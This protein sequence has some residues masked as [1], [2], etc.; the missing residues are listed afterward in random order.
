MSD[1][2]WSPP[3]EFAQATN[4]ARFMEK[5]GIEDVRSLL[6]RSV[7][8]HE[9][10]WDAIVEDL[11]IEFAEPYHTVVDA[12]RGN[13]WA[14]W[15]IGG[16][17]N[18]TAN[19]L[20]RHAWSDHADRVCL[21]SEREDGAV[22]ELTFSELFKL[23]ERCAAALVSLGVGKGDRVAAFMPMTHDVVVQMLAT[24]K[25]GAVFIPIFKGFQPEA[26]VTRLRDA[27]PKV[28]FAAD[29]SYWRGETVPIKGN[30]DAALSEVPGIRH[31]IVARYTDDDIVWNLDR[32]IAWPD[33]LNR[34]EPIP[35]S[36]M[37]AMD[38]AL[39]LYTS[40]T[41]GSAKGTVH[42]HA[43]ALVQIAK[44][45]GY[46][47]DVK[48]DDR[49]FWLTDIGWMMGPWSIIGGL[50]HGATVVLYDGLFD[51]PS[52]DRLWEMLARHRVTV[53]GVSPTV[54]RIFM[55]RDPEEVTRHDLSSLRILGS[56]GEPCDERT[57]HWYFETVGGSRCPV[58][59]V[60]GG[61]DILGS[62]LSPL[63]IVPLK[64]CSLAAPGLGMAVDVWSED[65][66][67]VRD[68]V[69]YL[70]ATKPAPSMTRGLWND[71][72]RYMETYWSTWPE[73]WNHG[74]WAHID[75]DGCWFVHGRADDTIKV[76]GR[77][78]GPAEI[79][80]ALMASGKVAEA[81]AVGVPHDVKGEGI[82]CFVV[83]NPGQ[84]PSEELRHELL[85]SVVGRLGKVCKPDAILF[86]SDL[87]KTSNAMILRR[88]VRDTYLGRSI[89]D[90]TS[91][92]NPEALRAITDA[93]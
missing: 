72:D 56:T 40:G 20:E 11:G 25:I 61:T 28:L 66:K 3:P 77:R 43:G 49:L 47:F 26:M 54:M 84:D 59:N 46:A 65:G 32:D 6:K 52:R 9:W 17:L 15:Y 41:S 38:P 35:T 74:D 55:R 51:Y 48:P 23:V 76:S 27:E 12:S 8:E 93:E 33:F 75:K 7:D 69:G 57:W 36:M 89:G 73:V 16:R 87:P 83:P 39:I 37:D 71:P 91:V 44:E 82:V 21:I 70:V 24:F 58:I 29:G 68:E 22:V 42:S 30:T 34:G 92:H 53:F 13:A 14:D 63:P 90:R 1:F 62:F 80:G 85:V 5:H 2:V 31:V 79:E 88:L 4:V 45:T 81:A 10:F 18:L 86:V 60:S 19:C 67:P 78:I 64:P 50:F